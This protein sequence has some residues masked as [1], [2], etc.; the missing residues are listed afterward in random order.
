MANRLITAIELRLKD[1]FSRGIQAAGKASAGFAKET[2][3]AVNMVDKALSGTA[4]TLASFGLAFSVGAA[5][6]DMIALDHWLTR[7]G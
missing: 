2:I 6:S 3:G 7:L 4:A 5:T 1:G